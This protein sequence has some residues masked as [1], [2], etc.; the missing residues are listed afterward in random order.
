MKKCKGVIELNEEK[1]SMILSTICASVSLV[2][3]KSIL[4]IVLISI[5]ILNILIVLI[6]KLFRYLKDGKL[7]EDEIKDIEATT[8]ELNNTIKKGR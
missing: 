1:T 7:T 4:D 6:I 2:D 8:N 3:F 5:S